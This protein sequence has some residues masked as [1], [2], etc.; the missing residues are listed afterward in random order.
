MPDKVI[1]S[2]ILHQRNAVLLVL[3]LSAG[4]LR[5]WQ[6]GDA[7]FPADEME[8]F[9]LAKRNASITELWRNPPWL[10]QI[11]LNETFTLL[12]V[13]MGM[14]ATPFGTRLPFAIMGL[15]ALFFMWRFAIRY[16]GTR[17]AT[18]VLIL[19]I[20][21]PY[22]LYYARTA[23]HYAGATCWSAAMILSLWGVKER[24][25]EKRCPS[26]WQM[27]LW[28]GCAI[29]ACHMHMS[30]WIVA[31]LQGGL[32]LGFGLIALRQ[33]KPER[34]RFVL[35]T[36]ISGIALA[37]LMSRWIYRAIRMVLDAVEQIGSPVLPELT[38]LFPAYFAGENRLAILLLLVVAAI[39]VVAF[40]LAIRQKTAFAGLGWFVVVHIAA[41]MLY[42]GFAGGGVAKITYF[43][44]I[45]PL[46][47]GFLGIGL[48]Q[49]VEALSKGRQWLQY[50]ALSLILGAYAG[51]TLP[52]VWAIVRLE[53]KP[54]A[55][56]K[57]N[58]WMLENLPAGTPVFVDHWLHPWNQLAI[59]N[60]SNINYTF[61]VPDEPL[62]N[63][64][65]MNWRATV[66]TFFD[67]Y[68]AAALLEVARDRYIET[69]GPWSFPAQ[70]FSRMVSITNVPAMTLRKYKVFP[71]L[72][73][74]AANTNQVVTRIFYN[75]PA[76]LVDAARKDARPTLRIYGEGWRY[77]KPWQPMP[78]WPEPLMQ[79][80]WVQAGM[81]ADGG[82]MLASLDGMQK[83][84]Q[85]QAMQYLNQGRWAD[86]RIPGARSTLRLFNLTDVDLEATLT[87]TGIALSG[88][89]R[90]M[91]GSDVFAFPQTLMVERNVP[92]TLKPGENEVVV[93]LPMNQFMLVHDV[94]LSTSDKP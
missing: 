5:F 69:V 86:Y 90:C 84:P 89:V 73:Y 61:T 10:N 20:F 26:I 51:L 82:K 11:P 76:D 36:L 47:I 35:L 15:L 16:F 9:K 44:A 87:V 27:F 56:H 88:N 71:K 50:G 81:Y 65:G 28:L 13:K 25:D 92:L 52:A 93:S 12:L 31:G 7:P 83:M 49:G 80:L 53:G 41:L 70:H 45:W 46:F 24:L 38:R 64:R 29:L 91:I 18:C 77:L 37:L 55:T 23:Y 21:N 6:L 74:A 22:Q 78:G 30:V 79:A 39:A 1:P 57:I 60:Q 3:L 48:W 43:S 19:A 67:K 68:P 8:F 42:V 54:L 17:A 4:I 75:T 63:Y 62:V 66:P 32:M 94:R 2:M 58:A 34:N 40:V 85:Q 14:P 59:H 33:T 72:D